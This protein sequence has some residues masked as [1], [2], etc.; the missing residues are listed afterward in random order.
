MTNIEQIEVLE[1]VREK[2]LNGT[3]YSFEGLCALIVN[4]L[5]DRLYIK[6]GNIRYAD[7]RYRDLEEYIPLFTHENAIKHANARADGVHHN[8]YWWACYPVYNRLDRAKFIDWIISK[9]EEEKNAD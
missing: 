4:E 8:G 7:I 3:C 2:V 6:E 5:T 9:L 1:T